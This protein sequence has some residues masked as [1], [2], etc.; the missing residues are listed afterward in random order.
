MALSLLVTRVES[1]APS[2]LVE[3][4]VD[5]QH[6]YRIVREG[7]LKAETSLD[8][9]T[10]DF[11]AMLVP[12]AGGGRP[13]PPRAERNRRKPLQR[14]VRSISLPRLLTSLPRP[15]GARRVDVADAERREPAAP[16]Q[17]A[18]PRALRRAG[19]GPAHQSPG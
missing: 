11:K 8:I 1:S 3:L 19:A 12:D 16:T 13:V 5:A 6:F 7:I 10:A 15:L 18:A 14:P 17:Q 9:S 2:G 4:V